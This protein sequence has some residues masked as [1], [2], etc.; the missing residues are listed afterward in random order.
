MDR[1]YGC[2]LNEYSITPTL[3]GL[4]GLGI[5]I[6]ISKPLPRVFK[7]R[8]SGTEFQGPSKNNSLLK[9]KCF[10]K[11]SEVRRKPGVASFW[12]N[13]DVREGGFFS[14]LWGISEYRIPGASS[15]G[16]RLYS[17]D[18]FFAFF[19]K[20]TMLLA[21]R[22]K[23][24]LLSHM[25][26]CYVLQRIKLWLAIATSVLADWHLSNAK[27]YPNKP[28]T[29]ACEWTDNYIAVMVKVKWQQWSGVG[30]QVCF[31]TSGDVNAFY[32]DLIVG[33]S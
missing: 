23:V 18:S 21:Q 17:P 15:K 33:H 8:M 30:P 6:S 9:A 3:H 29:N 12:M 13:N 2:V 31:V 14:F 20:L 10:L 25:L 16:Q 22:K 4:L 26:C 11:I 5:E 19:A 27:I 32:G 28:T 1:G 7:S 24:M